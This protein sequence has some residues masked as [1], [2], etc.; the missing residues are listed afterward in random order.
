MSDF[1]ILGGSISGAAERMLR[2]HDLRRDLVMKLH[3]GEARDGTVVALGLTV[4]P[5]LRNEDG[6]RVDLPA[7]VWIEAVRLRG[8]WLFID[9][10]VGNTC[11]DEDLCDLLRDP[12]QRCKIIGYPEGV[13]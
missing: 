10:V 1:E 9:Y 3:S 11:S 4:H 13:L 12:H 2:T 7:P 5:R 8:S 6:S